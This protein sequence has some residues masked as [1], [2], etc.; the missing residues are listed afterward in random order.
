MQECQERARDSIQPNME[1]DPS[2]MAAIEKALLDCMG[3]QVNEHIKLLQ[4]MKNR[5]TSA[6]R[7]FK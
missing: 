2:K 3:K 6:L 4:P 7:N 1:N 5:I